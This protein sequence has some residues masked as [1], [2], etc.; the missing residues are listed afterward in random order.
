MGSNRRD[1]DFGF[2]VP[3]PAR[4]FENEAQNEMAGTL[5]DTIPQVTGLKM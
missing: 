2:T 5:G 1:R 4:L 3:A